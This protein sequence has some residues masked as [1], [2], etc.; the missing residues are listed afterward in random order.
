MSVYPGKYVIGLTGNIATGKS[1]VRKM[2][3]FLGAFGIDADELAYLALALDSTGYHAVRNGFGDRFLNEDRTIDRSK[4]ANLVFRDPDQLGRLEAI[5]HPLVVKEIENQIAAAKS[6]VFV[7]EAIKLIETSLH[8]QCD[9]LWVTASNQE[10]QMDRLM[11]I[12]KMDQA[13]ALQRIT[14]QSA[15]EEKI[16]YADFVIRNND[17]IANTWDQVLTAWLNIFPDSSPPPDL[18]AGKVV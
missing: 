7:I 17:S 5:V 1:L 2:L 15:Q 16:S 12:R 9:S 13:E 8:E 6:D 18:P 11:K 4:L 10:N 14:A 3:E